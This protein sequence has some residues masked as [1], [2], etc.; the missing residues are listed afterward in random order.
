MPI[1][2]DASFVRPWRPTSPSSSSTGSPSRRTR[3]AYRYPG[4][5]DLGVGHLAGDRRRRS[6]GSRPGCSRSASS[7][8]SGSASPSNTRYEW[9]LADLAIMCAGAA[10]TTVYPSTNEDDTAYIL[11]DSEC[12]VVF[13]EDDVQIAKLSGPPVRAA[14][15]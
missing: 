12:Q 8:S 14:A 6:R 4:G 15:R 1:T 10:T 13:A 9:I 3:E 11:S 5:R 7:P 2:I